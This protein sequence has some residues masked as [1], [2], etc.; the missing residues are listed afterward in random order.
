MKNAGGIQGLWLMDDLVSILISTE[1]LD[2][3][4]EVVAA[5]A[6]NIGQFTCLA[7]LTCNPA[8]L[9]ERFKAGP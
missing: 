6:S 9:V 7:R 8:R 1:W 3:D 4:A 2:Y 5:A